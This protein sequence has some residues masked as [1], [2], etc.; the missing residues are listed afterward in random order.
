MDGATDQ[1][2][3]NPPVRPRGREDGSPPFAA[4]LTYRSP[5]MSEGE[6]MRLCGWMTR[7]MFDRYNIIDHADLTRAVAHRFSTVAGSNG[8]VTA[9][10]FADRRRGPIA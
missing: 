2:P 1:L 9:N 6:I 5:G 7:D 8:K 10:K 3:G 4:G